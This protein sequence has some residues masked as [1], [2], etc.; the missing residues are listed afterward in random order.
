MRRAKYGCSTQTLN[1]NDSCVWGI[2]CA[3]AR[4]ICELVTIERVAIDSWLRAMVDWAG[5]CYD[6]A[7]YDI[8]LRVTVVVSTCKFMKL[9]IAV[10]VSLSRR[11]EDVSLK[12]S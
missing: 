10:S 5:R 8:V 4:R 11:H 3:L 12:S 7:R 9:V 6:W 2:R 1:E